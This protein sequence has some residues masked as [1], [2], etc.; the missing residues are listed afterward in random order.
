MENSI[1]PARHLA[2]GEIALN[3]IQQVQDPHRDHQLEHSTALACSYNFQSAKIPLSGLEGCV[4]LQ[5]TVW[6]HSQIFRV[7][8]AGFQTRK[9]Q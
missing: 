3:F 6:E 7:A 1:Y 5:K 8:Q 9:P 4:C 2:R